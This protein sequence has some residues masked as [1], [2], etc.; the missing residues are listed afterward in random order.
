LVMWGEEDEVLT[1]GQIPQLQEVLDISDENLIIYEDNAHFLPE[2]VPE[3]LVN[4]ITAFL[5]LSK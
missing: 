3:D 4:R 5:S 2:E 1:T